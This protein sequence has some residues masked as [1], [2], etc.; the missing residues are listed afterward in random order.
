MRQWAGRYA[1]LVNRRGPVDSHKLRAVTSHPG[2]VGSDASARYQ[3]PKTSPGRQAP[4]RDRP[5]ASAGSA[6]PH[7]ALSLLYFLIS[8]ISQLLLSASAPDFYSRLLPSDF[9][10]PLTLSTSPVVLSGSPLRFSSR[11]SSPPAVLQITMNTISEQSPGLSSAGNQE[12]P[13]TNEPIIKIR[14]MDDQELLTWIQQEKPKLL[15]DEGLENFK[16]E[17]ISGDV[18]LDHAG[19]RQFFKECKLRTG[20]SDGL[21]KLAS[22]SAALEDLANEV[23]EG[24]FIPWM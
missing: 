4:A 10:S 8:P 20:P 14:N 16:K 15:R 22:Q 18:F 17:R 12:K 19:D 13:V 11:H 9:L 21:A 3:C 5:G 7:L 2:S 23:K 6:A 24:K 1:R